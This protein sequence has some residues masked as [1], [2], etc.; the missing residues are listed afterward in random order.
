MTYNSI[1][2][3]LQLLLECFIIFLLVFSSEKADFLYD[4][5]E[6][7][8]KFSKSCPLHCGREWKPIRNT[9]RKQLKEVSSKSIVKYL[10]AFG[11]GSQYL[12]VRLVAVQTTFRKYVSKILSSAVHVHRG[13]CHTP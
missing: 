6:H 4:L 5:P 13:P 8:Y 9:A 7:S 11:V 2:I 10:R 1:C 3:I 12:R